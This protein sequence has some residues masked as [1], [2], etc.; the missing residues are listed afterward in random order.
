MYLSKPVSSINRRGGLMVGHLR[1]PGVGRLMAGTLVG[2][3]CTEE[4]VAGSTPALVILFCPFFPPF[5]GASFRVVYSRF[6]AV[7]LRS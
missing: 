4:K 5:S 1:N 7:R 3:W 2:T 6:S